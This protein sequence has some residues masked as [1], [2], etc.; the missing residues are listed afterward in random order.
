MCGIAGFIDF[1]SDPDGKG[2]E[3]LLQASTLL[4]HRG[5]D[6]EGFLLLDSHNIPLEAAG[7]DTTI[8]IRE[9]GVPLLDQLLPGNARAGLLHRRLAIIAPDAR[10]HQPMCDV[11]RKVWISFN[12][13]IYNFKSLRSELESHGF[14][15]HTQTD[16]EVLLHAWK[17]WG[18]ECLHRLDGMWAFALLDLNRQVFFAACDPAGIKPFYH[19]RHSGGLHFASEIKALLSVHRPQ[20]NPVEVARFL[21]WGQSDEHAE[22]HFAGIHRLQGGQC[23]ELPLQRASDWQPVRWHQ[24]ILNSVPEEYSAPAARL[25]VAE[26]REML[27]EVVALR[28]QS[29]VPVGLCLSGGIDSSAIAGLVAAASKDQLSQFPAQAFMSVLPAG[30]QPDESPFARRMAAAAGLELHTSSPA[31]EEFL[32]SLESMIY[33]LDSPPPGMNA[34]SQYALF[35]L[36]HEQGVRVSLDGQGA[37]ELFG[38]YPIHRE[39]ALLE[40]LRT[41]NFG[42]I[43]PGVLKRLISNLLRDVLP[44]DISQSLLAQ[45]K[46]ELSIFGHEVWQLAGQKH[47]RL[48]SG[49]NARLLHDHQSGILP[50]LLKAAD[51]N[52][53]RWSVESRM[54]FADAAH[55]AAKLFSLPGSMKLAGNRSKFLLREAMQGFVPGEILNR[56]DKIGF[57]APDKDWLTA[58]LQSDFI[59]GLPACKEWLDEKAFGKYAAKF[60]KHP[61]A[62]DASIL[63]R[64]IAFRIWVS[65]F[66]EKRI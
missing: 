63:W 3:F 40:H 2:G 31:P 1:H 52:S 54:P 28:L 44:E 26:I 65:V 35:R 46:P 10:G 49:L 29:D 7:V 47:P 48:E 39:L 42:E 8:A 21:A 4:Q 20:L 41:G 13:E 56:K 19:R 32:E 66:L 33:T 43:R 25:A 34:F 59:H 24:T 16:T 17:H 11:Q 22:T 30:S 45:K 55:L 27:R 36:V 18:R 14:Q 61:S 60:L 51:R 6:D 9:R 57:A 38:G 15:F 5:P 12:G 23:I 64:A 50:F 58:L 37:D 62:V 53:M